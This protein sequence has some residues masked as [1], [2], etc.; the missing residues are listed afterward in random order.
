MPYW[1]FP[2][3]VQR[4]KDFVERTTSMPDSVRKTNS[5]RN[6]PGKNVI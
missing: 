1:I 6:S 3:E 4:Q 2:V 5:V